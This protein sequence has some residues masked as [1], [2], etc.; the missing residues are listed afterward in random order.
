MGY[1]LKLFFLTEFK[2]V[3]NNWTKENM[4]LHIVYIYG[5]SIF[6]FI[7]RLQ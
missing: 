6:D 7:I 5:D 2:N 3:N 4:A 1:L